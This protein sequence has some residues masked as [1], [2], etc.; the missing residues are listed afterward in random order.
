MADDTDR[1][2]AA[3]AAEQHKTRVLLV[4][5]VVGIPV[6]ALLVLLIVLG[7]HSQPGGTV[8]ATTVMPTGTD[9]CPI[10]TTADPKYGGLC[11]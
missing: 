11:D 7:A 10:G 6:L 5:L 3:N 1:V 9:G 8:P 4:W 2:I